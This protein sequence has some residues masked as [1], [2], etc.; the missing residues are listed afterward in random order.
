MQNYN[1]LIRELV[2]KRESEQDYS[3]TLQKL[4]DYCHENNI[5]KM[6]IPGG[7]YPISGQLIRR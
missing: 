2:E 4:I 5:G 7:D 3:E 1:E 6:N